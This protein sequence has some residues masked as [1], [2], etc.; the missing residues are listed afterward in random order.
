M[1]VAPN[2]NV[3]RKWVIIGSATNLCRGSGRF[4]VRRNLSRSLGLPTTN[5]KVVGTP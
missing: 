5:T 4:L 1:V 2:M 3:V